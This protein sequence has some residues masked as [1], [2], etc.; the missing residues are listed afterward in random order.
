M[1][2][3]RRLRRHGIHGRARVPLRVGVP[4]AIKTPTRAASGLA[5]AAMA[6]VLIDRANGVQ[7]IVLASGSAISA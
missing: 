2:R 6:P 1:L 7:T 3:V 4:A 5:E